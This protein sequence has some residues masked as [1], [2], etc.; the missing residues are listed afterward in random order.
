MELQGVEPVLS[1]VS[2]VRR[3]TRPYAWIVFALTVGLLLSDYM[4]RQVLNA[5]FSPLKVAWHLSDAEL[6]ALN[7][8]VALIVGTLTFPIAVLADRWGRV[9]SIVLM[10]SF[11]SLATLG[12]AMS[13]NY[14][15]ML[16][17][18]ALVGIGEA[19]YGAVGPAVYLRIFPVHLR[20][21]LHGIFTAGGAFGSVIGMALGGLIASHLGWRWSFG[22]MAGFGL[23]FVV[24]YRVVVT[25]ARLARH[26]IGRVIEKPTSLGMRAGSRA[27]FSSLFSAKSIRCAYLGSGLQLFVIGALYAWMPSYL[28]RYYGMPTGRAAVVAAC[29]VLINGVGTIT[30]GIVTDRIGKRFPARQW[31]M[32]A[33]YCLISMVLLMIAFRMHA[34]WPQLALLGAGMFVACGT[35][36]PS[37]A[38][39][40]NLTPTSIHASAFATLAVAYNVLGMAPGP[41]VAGFLADRIGLYAA[42]QYVP[43]ISVA[44][45]LIFM[46]GRRT[47]ES[48]L[49]QLGTLREQSP[50]GGAHLE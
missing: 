28:N 48:D 40:A 6:G 44:S 2:G 5:V 38:M 49:R 22:A 24:A 27:L 13:G 11:W 31:I 20:A 21:T 7:G 47:Y 39:V 43:L 50:A 16:A 25:E 15:Q 41:F 19:S 12:C 9:K 46:I 37:G 10:A 4:S 42:L 23:V 1:R 30:C 33:L 32:A 45:M 3:R 29:L 35:N 14:G 36:G 18:R 8:I 17:A 34:G 26:Q